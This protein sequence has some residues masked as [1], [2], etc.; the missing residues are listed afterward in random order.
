MGY[1]EMGEDLEGLTQAELEQVLQKEKRRA[2]DLGE[3]IEALE[4]AIQQA[5]R[6][7]EIREERVVRFLNQKVREIRSGNWEIVARI[8]SEEEY[9]KTNLAEK[10]DMCLRSK[11]EIQ[12]RLARQK[13]S[14]VSVLYQ[15]IQELEK[16]MNQD[17][18]NSDGSVAIDCAK[19]MIDIEHRMI[20]FFGKELH[21]LR[22]DVSVLAARNASLLKRVSAAQIQVMTKPT[23][24][25]TRN[26]M[27][28]FLESP[29]SK[30]RRCSANALG[31]AFG[32]TKFRE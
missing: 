27:D 12:D 25:V 15:E 14:D 3:I 26:E 6:T 13:A 23:G 29:E 28:A 9:T 22:A 21:G 7:S 17:L 8:Q 1:L 30:M 18:E 16:S 2:N 5:E 11:A 10:L 20:D 31:R 4:I 32:D 24:Q 19:Q